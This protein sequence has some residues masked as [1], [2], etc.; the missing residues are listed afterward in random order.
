MKQT[1]LMADELTPTQ[2]ASLASLLGHPGW[3]VVEELFMSACKRASD[4]VLKQDP[5]EE[6]SDRIIIKLQLRARERNEFSLLVLNS[7]QWHIKAAEMQVEEKEQ[8]PTKNPILKGMNNDRP[9]T[10]A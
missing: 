7:I 5:T 2:R 10:H 4:D 8:E 6:G 9:N 1:A 3:L